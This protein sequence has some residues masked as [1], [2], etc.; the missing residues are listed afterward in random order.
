M[1]DFTFEIVVTVSA[2]QQDAAPTVSS[3]LFATYGGWYG[4]NL[5]GGPFYF[6]PRIKSD[7]VL[8]KEIGVKF[9]NQRSGI[10]FGFIDIA[11]EDQDADIIDFVSKVTFAGVG[12]Y[13]V[14][15]NGDLTL[16][17]QP[18]SEDIGF[19]DENTIR[20]RLES[21]VDRAFDLPI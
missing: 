2:L 13:R 7:F 21:I 17:A 10:D 14:E 16:V 12:I 6:D 1:A 19:Q 9:W 15:Q 20:F 5:F 18:V 11:V 3:L 4:G 8:T